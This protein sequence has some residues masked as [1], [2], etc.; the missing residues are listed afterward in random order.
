M[1]TFHET[2][3]YLPS[4]LITIKDTG[5]GQPP[6]Q[7]EQCTFHRNSEG[8]IGQFLWLRSVILVSFCIVIVGLVTD[9]TS[10]L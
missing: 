2:I 7:R 4:V 9:M 5:T 6:A 8:D 3:I 10:G 1:H